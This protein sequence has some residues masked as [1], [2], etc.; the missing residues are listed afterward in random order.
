MDG[1]LSLLVDRIRRK[2]S[3]LKYDALFVP[4][5]DEFL[6]EQLTP[7]NERLYALTGFTGTAG[8]AIVSQDKTVLFTDSRYTEQAA[9]QTTFQVFDIA[10]KSPVD[11][12]K[13]NL[14]KSKIL[15]H[16][17]TIR[18]SLALSLTELLAKE[19]IK[20]VPTNTNLIDLHWYE[21]PVAL[22]AGSFILHRRHSGVSQA[23]KAQA[24]VEKMKEWDINYLIVS[25]A[26]SASWL[27]NRRSKLLSYQ[28]SVRFR[29][30]VDRS[31]KVVHLDSSHIK[32]LEGQTVGIDLSSIPFGL[33][34]KVNSIANVKL[35]DD[36]IVPM[37]AIKNK[38]EQ[39]AIKMICI[40][41]S[42]ALCTFIDDI[43]TKKFPLTEVSA[44]ELVQ[45]RRQVIND[46]LGDS[47]PPIIA[48]GPHAALPHYQATPQ[49]D[50]KID[51][52]PMV[53]IDTGGQY[54]RGTTDTTRTLCVGTPTELMKKR[55]TQVLKGHIALAQ[56]VLNVGDTPAKLD[57]AARQ[58]LR[59]DGVDYAHA[60]GHGI[61]MCLS[62][63]DK[64]PV[65]H[66]KSKTPIADGMVFSNEPAFY[67][68]ENGF[69]IRLEN[70]LLAKQKDDKIYF[71]NLIFAPFEPKLILTEML[72][73]SEKEWLKEYHKQIQMKVFPYLAQKLCTRLQPIID[74]F[75]N[76]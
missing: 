11:W 53:L 24:L 28:P 38:A 16:A 70:M 36:P 54:V 47:F 9:Q 17:G 40:F 19:K 39:A 74:F 26:D 42:T 67:D 13:E 55:Y 56:T 60:T 65:I 45:R 3:K 37:R 1:V 43:Y 18:A 23:V 73:D 27:A 71:E 41:E 46:Y 7:D 25:D 35:I 44:G 33:Y 30:L 29:L 63:H 31:G 58:F 72:T 5:T 2:L 14:K 22:S 62:V 57:I 48:V 10:K 6:S 61:G 51:S 68:V 20:F 4:H 15:F 50:V 49:T 12:I 75:I 34:E 52:A 66:E 59:A 76:L 21:G 69:G 64:E 8:V 32:E